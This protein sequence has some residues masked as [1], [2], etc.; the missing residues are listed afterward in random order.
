MRILSL[1]RPLDATIMQITIV[2][3]L[4]KMGNIQTPHKMQIFSPFYRIKI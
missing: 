1:L 4:W 2:E 3:A